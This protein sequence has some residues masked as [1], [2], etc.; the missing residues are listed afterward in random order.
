MEENEDQAS[1]N[2]LAI[3]KFVFICNTYN[4]HLTKG[5]FTPS[6]NTVDSEMQFHV[7]R[8]FTK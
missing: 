8:D 2:N 4:N 3:F 7:E 1:N 5:D 6:V